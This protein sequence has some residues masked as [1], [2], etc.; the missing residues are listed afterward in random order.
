MRGKRSFVQ[1]VYV[2]VA[3]MVLLSGCLG[4][5][6]AKK[7]SLEE[8]SFPEP[9]PQTEESLRIAVSAIISPEETFVYYKEV[10]DYISGES[11]LPVDLVLRDT[12]AEVNELVKQEELDVAFV[13]T[14]AYIDG[15]DEFGMELLVAPKAYGEA[16]YYSY[17]IVPADSSVGTLEGLRGT[18]FAFTDPM[19]NTGKLSPTY[20]LA[21]LNETPDS[22]FGN[23]IFTYSHDRSIEAVAEKIVDGAAVDSLVWD[24]LDATGPEFTSNTRIIQR[25]PPYGIPPVVVPKGLDPE[26]KE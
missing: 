15:Q 24:Y 1:L 22:F 12:Y 19:S 26:L 5:E 18:T 13:C 16:V 10:L 20:M 11:G 17:I 3:V 23:Y 14:G 6:E 4:S 21:L 2:A 8:V 25:S 7:V 9:S